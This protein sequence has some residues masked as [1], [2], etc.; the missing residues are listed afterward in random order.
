MVSVSEK[1][2]SASPSA[3]SSQQRWGS[4]TSDV[5]GGAVHHDLVEALGDHPLLTV[6]DRRPGTDPHREWIE[7]RRPH[8]DR[9]DAVT[10]AETIAHAHGAEPLELVTQIHEPVA[11]GGDPAHERDDVELG[12]RP[13]AGRGEV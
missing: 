3:T 13:R 1:P 8:L 11:G 9:H 5:F 10:R 12:R 7:P 2:S 4:A 6:D